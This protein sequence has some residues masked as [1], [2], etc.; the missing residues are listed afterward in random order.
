MGLIL[1][2]IAAASAWPVNLTGHRAYKPIRGMVDDAG[3]DWLDA[4]MERADK[5]APAFYAL[6]LFAAASLVLPHKWPRTTRPLAI[7]TFVL[8]LFCVG[9]GGWIALA[10]GGVR[11]PEFRS[12]DRPPSIVADFPHDREDLDH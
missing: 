3:A 4:H 2:L 7:T 9:A 8:G 10:G 12:A 1:V 6:A 5:G 11:H